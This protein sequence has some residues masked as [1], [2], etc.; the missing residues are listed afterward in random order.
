MIMA[1]SEVFRASTEGVDR[2]M[3]SP[4]L[5]QTDEVKSHT[6]P[7][8]EIRGVGGASSPQTLFIRNSEDMKYLTEYV[9]EHHSR[10]FR[11]IERR[12][13]KEPSLNADGCEYAKRIESQPTPFNSHRYVL[14]GLFLIIVFFR[15]CTY[16]GWNGLQDMLYKSGAFAWQCDLN[17]PDVTFQKIGEWDYVDC[18]ARKNAINDLYTSAFAASF[19]FSA[20][21][22][23][24]LDRVGPKFT[25]LGAILVDATG[26]ALLAGSSESFESYVPAL[27]FIGIAADPGY[28]SLLCISNLFPKKESTIMGVMGS[29]RS[30]S[31]A[32]PVVMAEIFKSSTMADDELW[33]VILVYIVVGLGICFIVCLLFVPLEPFMGAEDFRRVDREEQVKALRQ[34]FLTSLPA[35]FF[36]HWTSANNSLDKQQPPADCYRLV[37]TKEEFSV[38]MNTF[39]E[40]E[41]REAKLEQEDTLWA[42]LRNPMFLLLLPIFV[43][44]LLRVE[45][46]TKSNKEQLEVAGSGN[47]YTFFSIMNILTF[48]PGPVMGYLGDKFGLLFVL[49]LLNTAGIVMYALLLP[50]SLP[51]KGLS[52]F[53]FWIYASFVLSSIYCYIKAHFP[54]KFFGTLSGI[55]SLVGGCFALTSIGW[56]KLSTE[57][58][59]H[60]KPKNFWP[61]DGV[62]I[63]GGLLVLF[64]IATLFYIDKKHKEMKAKAKEIQVN[65]NPSSELAVAT[66][67]P[68]EHEDDADTGIR[69]TIEL[70]EEEVV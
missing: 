22:G 2:G 7:F 3:P 44:N 57:T 25:L 8:I 50:I 67:Q 21:G 35:S 11:E 1:S 24:I 26:W 34:Q 56:Y 59:L 65:G 33:K 63:G 9:K 19:I 23:L 37:L 54:N 38:V 18:P 53:F 13:G 41:K 47:L 60:L 42:A 29:M 6:T 10:R 32:V 49:T 68:T 17:D 27:V 15:G 16:W 14:L 48:L 52:I 12:W 4:P 39:L 20:V 64:F 5:P 58:L 40:M 55:C 51:C 43:M 69:G 36:S 28:L 45:F 62:M 30:L 46:F 66:S 61:V 31:F 70:K